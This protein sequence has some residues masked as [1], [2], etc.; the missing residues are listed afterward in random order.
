MV[1][2]LIK[3]NI[4]VFICAIVLAACVPLAGNY[5]EFASRTPPS[6]KGQSHVSDKQFAQGRYTGNLLDGFPHGEGSFRFWNGTT[7]EGSFHKGMFHGDGIMRYGDGTVVRGSF[8]NDR[9]QFV[10]LSRPDGAV[11]DGRVLRGRPA[12][13]GT[14]TLANN[15]LIR[16]KFDGFA[17]QGNA[18]LADAQGKVVY[19]GKFKGTTPHGEGICLSGECRRENGK[20]VT[21]QARETSAEQL[22]LHTVNSDIDSQLTTENRRHTETVA[23]LDTERKTVMEQYQRQAGPERSDSCYCSIVHSPMGCSGIVLRT[24]EDPQPPNGL[25]ETQRMAWWERHRAREKEEKRLRELRQE[26]QRLQCRQRF[27]DY[28]GIRE[29]PD[30][31][32]K[33]ARLQSDTQNTTARLDA[34]KRDE[35][36]RNAQHQRALEQERQQRLADK[37]EMKRRADQAAADLKRAAD[38]RMH[39]LKNQCAAAEFRRINPCKCTV[40]LGG[41]LKDAPGA[42]CEA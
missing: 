2:A 24:G 20:D 23:R 8:A 33:L 1:K 40:A 41:S 25:S 32:Q 11:F 27:A 7:Y 19:A 30:F 21:A 4:A 6:Q 14:L 34:A 26:Q 16:G 31:Q 36:A 17:V 9:E 35:M 3:S 42:A 12:G 22:A 38:Q 10:T 15:T 39:E 13:N 18:L 5:S 29:D 37:A 28:L